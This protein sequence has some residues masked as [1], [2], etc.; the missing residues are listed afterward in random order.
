MFT[1]QRSGEFGTYCV[2]NTPHCG[3]K[4]G[5]NHF[6]FQ[7]RICCDNEVLDESGFVIDNAQLNDV[8]KKFGRINYSCER[9]TRSCARELWRMFGKRAKLIQW[10]TVEIWGIETSSVEFKYTREEKKRSESSFFYI[11]ISDNEILRCLYPK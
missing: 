6:K 11:P 4:D 7:I 8:W 10:L 9:L 5:W 1:I 3:I 2:P